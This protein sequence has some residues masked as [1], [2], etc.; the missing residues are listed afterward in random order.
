[1]KYKVAIETVVYMLNI[2]KPF[3]KLFTYSTIIIAI[4]RRM[5]IRI[6]NR[7]SMP[8]KLK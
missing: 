6:Q 5:E 7:E 4:T 1:M 8:E 2:N 3:L